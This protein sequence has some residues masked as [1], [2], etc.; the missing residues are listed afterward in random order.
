MNK[1]DTAKLQRI[2]KQLR[3][4]W[5]AGALYM[6]HEKWCSLKDAI[7]AIDEALSPEDK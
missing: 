4:M 3:D 2:R 1:T 5:V 7:H 6:E